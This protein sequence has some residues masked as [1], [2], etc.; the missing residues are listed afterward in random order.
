MPPLPTTFDEPT[1]ELIASLQRRQKDLLEFQI[2]RLAEC[3][4][5]VSLQQD[6][7]DELRDDI[8]VFAEQVEE[9]DVLVGDQK[10]EKNRRE[11]RQT[12][13]E[14]K[15]TLTS[16]RKD[17]RSALLASKRTIDS[18]NKSN[19]DELLQSSSTR[20][21]PNLSEKN[22]EDLLMKA[23]DEVTDTLRRTVMMMQ[24]EL[25]KSVLSSQMLGITLSR[26]QDYQSTAALKSTSGTHDMLAN[27]MD[28][29]RILITALEKSDWLDRILIIAGFGFF[30]LV[31]LFILKQR[32][33]DRSIRMAFWWTRFIPDFSSDLEL[34]KEEKQ[35]TLSQA[36]SALSTT[37]AVSSTLLSTTI[38][39]L[40][41]S[42][43]KIAST[44]VAEPP[45]PPPVEPGER[46]PSGGE[47]LE[48]L[49]ST[50]PDAE[51]EPSD[52][53][54]DEAPEPDTSDQPDFVDSASHEELHD[55]L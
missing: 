8:T 24:G 49:E 3:Q 32:I 45:L 46:L 12:T 47:S 53:A 30:L 40:A 35:V 43:S 9:L 13:A 36:S 4:G 28:T 7:A 38:P 23:T 6:L 39:I 34:L 52:V 17:A 42:V 50:I 55:E 26:P 21:K 2:P 19:R 31:V 11:L 44:A 33:V 25:E 14:F 5:P 37:I 41:S 48:D 22:K 20:E 10:G 16:V 18:R 51:S 27:V 54:P 15:N 1:L 29:S